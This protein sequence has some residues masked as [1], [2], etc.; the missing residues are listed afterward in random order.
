MPSVFK[1]IPAEA[2]PG[3]ALLGAAAVAM[4]IANSAL[5]PAQQALLKTDLSAGFGA[6]AITLPLSGWVKNGLMAIFFFYAGLELKR[7]LLEGALSKPTAA[8]LPAAGAVGGMAL[9]ALIYLGA[10]GDGFAQGWAI[11]AA[12]DIAFALGVLALLGPRV[13]AALKAFLLAVAVID[14]LGAILIVAF[15][16]TGAI[17]GVWLGWAAAAFAALFGLNRLGVRSMWPYAVLAL[18]L[19]V[20]MQNSGVNPTLAG[21]LAAAVIPLRDRTGGSPLHD[22]EHRLRPWV[23]YGVMPIFALANAG[24]PLGA[25]LITALGHPVAVGTA[26]G[27]ALGKPVGITLAVLAAARA[28]RAPL[29]GTLAQVLGVAAVAGIGFTMSLFIGALAFDDPALAA[30]VRIGVYAGSISAAILGLL[31]LVRVL[32]PSAPAAGGED[33]THP[34]IGPETAYREPPPR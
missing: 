15:A 19:W 24:A 22:L 13:P 14:D 5:G 21:V 16:Y 3:L 25:G 12:T 23:L 33:P 9:P 8:I 17:S 27:L 4:L 32:P 31:I 6:A 7:E 34:F 29:P 20:A 1:R 11:P 2:W 18:P 26:L 10:A 30:P 28:M